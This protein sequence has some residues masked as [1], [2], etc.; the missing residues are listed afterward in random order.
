MDCI[1]NVYVRRDILA[2]TRSIT[3]ANDK[4]KNDKKK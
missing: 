1:I 2:N 4:Y 3:Q